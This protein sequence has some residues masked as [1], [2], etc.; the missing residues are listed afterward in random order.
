MNLLPALL[1]HGALAQTWEPR[2]WAP[3]HPGVPAGPPGRE[4]RSDLLSQAYDWYHS[5]VSARDGARCPYYPTCSAYGLQAVR[6]WGWGVGTLLT[7][8]RLLREYPW[9]QHFDHYPFVT[10]H[11]TPRLYDPVPPRPARK[12]PR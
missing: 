5:R 12:E 6:R 11:E 2:E 8:D 7:L 9:M 10:P 1:L 4:V 3:P